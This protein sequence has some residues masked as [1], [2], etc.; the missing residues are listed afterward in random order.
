MASSLGLHRPLNTAMERP[1]PTME[2]VVP[3]PMPDVYK[4]QV[5]TCLI[6]DEDVRQAIVK[7]NYNADPVSYTPLLESREK[8]TKIRPR[9]LAQAGR[10]PGVS[11][12]DLAQLSL[13]VLRFTQEKEQ[14]P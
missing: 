2:R 9:T 5:Y 10:I 1:T 8:L 13:A 4:R 6:D 7:T 14:H 12:S 3:R 11:P